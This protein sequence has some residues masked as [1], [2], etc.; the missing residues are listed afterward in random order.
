[1]SWQE[2]AR[3][4]LSNGYR[5]DDIRISK[6]TVPAGPVAFGGERVIATVAA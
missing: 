4:M 3:W 1:M 2:E 5:R 6:R